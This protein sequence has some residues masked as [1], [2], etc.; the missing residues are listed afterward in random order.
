MVT[1]I[2][3]CDIPSHL[4]SF[5]FELN[6]SKLK[7]MDKKEDIIVNS[8]LDWS[9]EFSKQKEIHEY[10]KGVAR[11]YHLYERTQFETEVIRATWLEDMRKWEVE[12]NQYMVKDKENEVR[13][14]DFM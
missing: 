1:F 9:M 13:Y 2:A 8:A 14:Y 11:K 7:L 5:S 10:M 4:Y 3:A 6:P 12:L